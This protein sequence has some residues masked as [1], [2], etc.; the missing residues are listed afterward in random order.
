VNYQPKVLRGRGAQRILQMLA[1][2][3]GQHGSRMKIEQNRSLL[4]L[5]W[6]TLA[7]KK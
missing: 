2:I 1:Q 6:S 3:S 4:E 5:P 7:P